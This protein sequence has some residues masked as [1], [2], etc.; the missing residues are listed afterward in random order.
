MF[1]ATKRVIIPKR[2]TR[3]YFTPQHCDVA[4]RLYN[5][6]KSVEPV[7]FSYIYAIFIYYFIIILGTYIESKQI[8]SM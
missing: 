2:S 6:L 5:P 3:F 1:M 7:V 4:V 8:M